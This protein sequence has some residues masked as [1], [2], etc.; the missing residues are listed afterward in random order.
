VGGRDLDGARLLVR[1]A[2]TPHGLA[3]TKARRQRSIPLHDRLRAILE[4]V[5][6]RRTW[7]AVHRR[8]AWHPVHLSRRLAALGRKLRIP[9]LDGPHV[10][11]RTFASQLVM[12]GVPLAQV[13]G[14]LGDGIGVTER[15]Y[16]HLAPAKREVLDAL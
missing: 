6:E 4:A 13:A 2:R 16:V 14:L 15:Y 10:L 5:E 3:P 12:A 7:V 8:H 11:R 9:E 1:A